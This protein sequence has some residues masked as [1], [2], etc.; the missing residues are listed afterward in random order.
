MTPRSN[1]SVERNPQAQLVGSFRGFVATGGPSR[2]MLGCRTKIQRKE[3]M[4]NPKGFSQERLRELGERLESH[5]W[6][7][8]CEVEISDICMCTNCYRRFHHRTSSIGKM[9]YRLFVLIRSA[10]LAAP[11]LVQ[12]PGSTLKTMITRKQ[13]PK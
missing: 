7:N 6:G 9:G 5:T 10:A 3:Y 12:L 11:L 8:R 13:I 2:Q 4:H 1:N